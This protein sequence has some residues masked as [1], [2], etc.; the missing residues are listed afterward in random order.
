MLLSI[1]Y[2]FLFIHIAKTGGT[3]IRTALNPLRWHDPY[4]YP[5]WLCGR[6]SQLTGHKIA[7]KLPRHAPIIAAKEMLPVELFNSLFKFAFVRNPWDLQVSSYYHLRRERPHLVEHIHDFAAFINWKLDDNRP[8]QYHVDISMQPQIDSLVDQ[9]GQLIVN[10]VGRYETL[11]DDFNQVCQVLKLP[12]I[13]L[14]H[15]RQAVD[16]K[17]DYRLYYTDTLAEK[18]ARHYQR[19][20]ITFGYQFDS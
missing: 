3:S 20:L 7:A 8:Y 19:D 11:S 1:R 6:L 2:Q 4:Y 12:P 17:K 10:F 5:M 14:P 18:V 15:K 13:K 9:R 16:R